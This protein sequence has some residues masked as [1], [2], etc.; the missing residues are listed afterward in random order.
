VL[1]VLKYTFNRI[2][3]WTECKTYKLQKRLFSINREGRE[4]DVGWE[5][6]IDS[7][8]PVI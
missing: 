6:N 5:G 4:I 8:R 3:N 2:K 1:T 7:S